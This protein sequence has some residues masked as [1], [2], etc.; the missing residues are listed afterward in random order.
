MCRHTS[1]SQPVHIS[2]G[3]PEVLGVAAAA[4][5]PL[6]DSEALPPAQISQHTLPLLL[7][8]L[9]VHDAW[10]PQKELMSVKMLGYLHGARL[11]QPVP[12]KDS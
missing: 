2:T 4:A 5:L 8:L 1:T 12:E 10:R 7:L 6:T 11:I 9:A 3:F